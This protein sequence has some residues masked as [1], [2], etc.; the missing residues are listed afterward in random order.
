MISAGQVVLDIFCGVGPF[1]VRAGK[2][3]CLVIANDL[4]PVAYEYLQKN[5]KSNKLEGQVLT[6]NEDARQVVANFIDKKYLT[7]N[8]IPEKFWHFDHVYMNLP[9]SAVEF[10]DSFRGLLKRS[11]TDVWHKQ[12]L[13]TIHLFS[14][15]RGETEEECKASLFQRIKKTL[16]FFSQEADIVSCVVVKKILPKLSELCVTFKLNPEDASDDNS[17]D[18]VQPEHISAEQP[19]TEQEETKA[20]TEEQRATQQ[21]LDI[22]R[23]EIHISDD[24][25]KKV[26]PNDTP[27]MKEQQQQQSE[28]KGAGK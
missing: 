14:M 11:T 12:N 16:K 9:V 8:K 24:V 4:N 25:K 13:P 20:Q 17:Y 22:Q 19:A 1:S 18:P 2:K 7:E 3:E 10:L 5:V 28:E 23:D 27:Q 26:K 21:Q 6:Y 15:A